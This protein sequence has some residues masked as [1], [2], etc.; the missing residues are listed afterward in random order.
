MLTP[1]LK[2]LM[3]KVQAEPQNTDARLYLA[4]QMWNAQMHEDALRHY[5]Q[6]IRANAALEEVLK[7]LEAYI[8]E[9]P[10]DVQAL[11]TLGDA[12]LRVGRIDVAEGLYKRA[13]NLL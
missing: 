11:R 2:A 8:Q 12:Y 13:I 9:T 7:D 5:T 3:E 1:E 10:Y 6:L 4:R